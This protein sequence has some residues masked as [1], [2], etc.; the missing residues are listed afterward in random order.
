MRSWRLWPP[1][2]SRSHDAPCA[3]VRN[4]KNP[5]ALGLALSLNNL[6]TLLRD[7][8]KLSHAKPLAREGLEIRRRSLP[9]DHPDIGRS[10]LLLGLLKLEQ[11]RPAE[12]EPL[13]REC[14]DIRLKAL[15]E[16]H[17]LTAEAASV[18]GDC[19]TSLER[20]EEAEPLLVKSYPI[21]K[22]GRGE[23]HERTL[24]ALRR[25]IRHY[26]VRGRPDS[27]AEHQRLLTIGENS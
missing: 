11:S 19:L 2:R 23:S 25:L 9:A 14:R 10:T 1:C 20:Y 27:A 24:E 22:A 21:I 3:D 7:L 4:T 5:G 6:G 15:P 18:L 13:L 8:G 12:A 17:H 16:G 26:E